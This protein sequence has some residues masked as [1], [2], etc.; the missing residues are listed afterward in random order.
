MN[1]TSMRNT[2][3]VEKMEFGEFALF[4]TG[5]G[6]MLDLCKISEKEVG[7]IW[8]FIRCIHNTDFCTF[9]KTRY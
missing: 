6:L 9:V 7:T 2:V 1:E 3:T 8:P 4:L 5:F